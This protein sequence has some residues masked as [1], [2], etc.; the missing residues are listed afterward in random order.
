MIYE[1]RIYETIPGR[2]P[3][4]NDRFA[5]HTVGFFEKHG[6]HVVGFW[7][8]E[9]GTSN[10]LVYMLGFDSLADREQ[11]W[12]RLPSRPR[13]A[14]GPSRVGDRRADKRPRPQCDSQANELLA[15]AVA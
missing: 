1:L 13:L 15:Y 2:L 3:A 5:N 8:E 12:A 6:I 10:Q 7:T 9:I 11:K 4:L 14:P